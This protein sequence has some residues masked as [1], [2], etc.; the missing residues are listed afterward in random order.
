MANFIWASKKPL[1]DMATLY[2][3]NITLNKSATAY[4]ETAYVV[5]LGLDK[6]NLL[7]AVKPVTKEEIGLGYVPEEQQHNI[8]VKS[9]YSRICNK[10]FM[11][12]ISDLLHLDFSDNQSYK[13]KADWS[14]KDK[15]LLIN[16]KQ[17]EV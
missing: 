6:E 10:L 8:T 1:D 9:S 7:I 4:F 12:E 3:S 5:L 14:E 2:E 15:A 13:F 11:Q 17:K 16:L